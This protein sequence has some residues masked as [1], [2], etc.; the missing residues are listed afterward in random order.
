MGAFYNGL[1]RLASVLTGLV[2]V[3]AGVFKLM[4]PVGATLVVE[5][6]F[7]FMHLGFMMPL[8][9]GTAVLLAMLECGIGAALVTGVWQKS[10]AI[11][12]GV[13]IAGFTLLTLVLVIAN[14]KMECGCFGEVIHLTHLQTFIKN[15]ILCALWAIAF[16]PLGLRRQAQRIKFFSFWLS[17]ASIAL[18]TLYSCFSIPLVDFTD[19]RPGAEL[20]A[21]IDNEWVM[22]ENETHEGVTLSFYDFYG[23]YQDDLAAEGSVMLVSVN[24]PEALSAPDWNAIADY[25][26]DCTQA[27]FQPLLLAASAPTLIESQIGEMDAARRSV[28]LMHTYFAD[29]RTLLTLNRSNGGAV[30]VRDGEIIAK[31][32]RRL[33]PD[34][35]ALNQM[36][37][38]EPLEVELR[39]SGNGK[40]KLEAFI[41]YLLAVMV[42]I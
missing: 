33:R 18:F 2:F 14:P 38:D 5:A 11:I 42:L 25:M 35:S 22:D 30:Y 1:R 29:N 41:L 20:A 28:L 24:D 12:S 32:S 13:V 16:V 6:Y 36:Y 23:D 19:F 3:L 9:G 37:S 39:Q 15:L 17:I 7:K 27:G 4:D 40:F 8:A 34:A 10:T 26:D 21:S 31:W